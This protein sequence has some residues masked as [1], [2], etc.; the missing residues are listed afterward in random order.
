ME[1]LL[2]D[3]DTIYFIIFLSSIGGS[4]ILVKYKVNELLKDKEYIKQRLEDMENE[5][6]K[7]QNKNKL[8]DDNIYKTFVNKKELDDKVKCIKEKINDLHEFLRDCK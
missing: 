8:D 1:E 4:A 2:K 7:L 5:I 6:I 3:K